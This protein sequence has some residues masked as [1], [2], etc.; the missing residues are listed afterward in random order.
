MLITVGIWAIGILLVTLFYKITVS[1]RQ[2][3]AS[4]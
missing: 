1:V 4:S 3:V 2:E